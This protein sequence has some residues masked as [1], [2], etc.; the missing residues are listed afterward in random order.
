LVCKESKEY[1]ISAIVQCC[2]GGY[3]LLYLEESVHNHS[4]QIVVSATKRHHFANIFVGFEVLT[5]VVMK[6]T[7]FWVIMPYSPLKVNRRFGGVLQ[8]RISRAR[9]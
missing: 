1:T 4:K 5:V 3:I 8:G 9:Y 7:V 2:L 6:H